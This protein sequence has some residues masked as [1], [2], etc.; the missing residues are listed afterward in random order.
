MG[1]YDSIMFEYLALGAGATK[2]VI[3][4]DGCMFDVR[5]GKPITSSMIIPESSLAISANSRFIVKSRDVRFDSGGVRVV[6]RRIAIERI[7]FVT[8]LNISGVDLLLEVAVFVIFIG[9]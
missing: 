7:V 9:R 6:D 5:V 4:V 1:T 3:A 8:C 2:R